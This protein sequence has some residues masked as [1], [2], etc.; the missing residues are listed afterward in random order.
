M[1]GKIDICPHRLW[2][3]VVG[4]VQ[5]EAAVDLQLVFRLCV[6]QGVH[7]VS[8]LL[9]NGDDLI[10]AEECGYAGFFFGWRL[11]ALLGAL[12]FCLGF[13]DPAGDHGR[14]S[15]SVECR[16]VARELCVAFGKGGSFRYDC[17]LGWHVGVG[18]V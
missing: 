17:G 8:E 11:V 14:V 1:R 12:P 6:P 3:R 16:A 10:L 15:T 7:E 2:F 4:Q 18:L 13:G 9:D 5:P